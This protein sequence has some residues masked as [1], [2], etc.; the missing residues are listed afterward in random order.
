MPSKASPELRAR[1]AAAKR[2]SRRALKL[3][4]ISPN[5]DQLSH[6]ILRATR[7]RDIR[8]VVSEAIE[9]YGGVSHMVAAWKFQIDSAI[10]GSPA[11]L[12]ALTAILRLVEYSFPAPADL[13]NLSDADLSRAIDDILKSRGI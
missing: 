3:G 13:D 1:Q 8:R 4:I 5:L 12:R 11:K 9:A 2:K 6:D 7:D 10:D